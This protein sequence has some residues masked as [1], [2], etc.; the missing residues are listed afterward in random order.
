MDDTNA[1]RLET[2]HRSCAE[3]FADREQRAA[4]WS[5]V[6]FIFYG[7]IATAFFGINT[8]PF[9]V[10]DEPI[11]F[12]RAAQIAD[13]GFVG[14]R[15]AESL[16]DGRTEVTGGGA[17]DPAL[18]RAAAPFNALAFHPE[19]R[20][21]QADWAPNVHWS[22]AR[23]L[24]SFPTANYPPFFYLPSA[25]GILAGREFGLSVVQSLYLSRLLTGLAA[26]ALGALAIALAYGA[27]PW[28]FTILTLP[29]SL[30]L[31]ASA[32]QDALLIACGALAG[33]LLVRGIRR[34]VSSSGGLLT[35]LAI[36]LSLVAMARPPFGAL[37]LL[38]LGLLRVPLWRR[39][40]TSLVVIIATL[41]WARIAAVT[42]LSNFGTIVGANPAAQIQ[43]I[44]HQPLLAIK[45]IG[46]TV[47]VWKAY[48]AQFIGVLGWMD[49]LLPYSYYRVATVMLV[50][51]AAAAMLGTKGKPMMSGSYLPVAAGIAL[52]SFGVFLVQYVAWTAPGHATV[53]G[54]EGCYFLAPALAGATLLP[55][56]GRI[57]APRLQ[58]ALLM[59]ILAFPI[60]SLAVTMRAVVLR[61]YL[62]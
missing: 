15:F 22:G 43:L 20:A 39:I 21:K 27:A 52:A 58:T 41:A 24:V 47:I 10:A 28:I 61:Y 19:L 29:M 35:G 60:V 40:L 14:T 5:S 54:I 3:D 50:V 25:A 31:M 30:S 45:A 13:G 8:P 33:A 38:P 23:A 18:A 2:S 59:L 46:A 9:Q 57:R 55:S 56:L 53:D 36:T 44:R 12:M 6:A 7:L 1:D 62:G 4:R 16:A 11:H 34:P 17:I 51:A 49:T 32:S 42:S 37:A 26:V 48:L